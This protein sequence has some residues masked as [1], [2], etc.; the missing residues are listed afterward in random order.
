MSLCQAGIDFKL[1]TLGLS[2]SRDAPF[3]RAK[4]R[5]PVRLNLK[6][7]QAARVIIGDALPALIFAVLEL[8][9]PRSMFARLL[10]AA[11]LTC[12]V[13]SSGSAGETS[14][15]K[16]MLVGTQPDHPWATHMYLHECRMLAQCLRLTP[17]VEAVVVEDWPRDPLALQRV[18]SLVYYSRPAGD[19]V[20]SQG[21]RA[22][23]EKLMDEGT[24]FVA[25]HWATDADPQRG[26]DYLNVLGGWFNFAHS[27][28]KIT[29][30]PLRQLNQDH[31]ICRGWKEYPLHDEIYLNLK[32]HQQA[33]PLVTIEVD[34]KDQTVAW[35]FE[36]PGPHPGRSFG[37]TLGHFH[38][39][40]EIEAFRR[41]LVNGILWTAKVDVPPHGA[42]VD[43]GDADLK[44][45]PEPKTEKP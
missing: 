41:F 33:R 7:S 37:T 20:L 4:R 42:A 14:A 12:A 2:Q 17:G 21:H 8:K 10:S 3:T 39:N 9:G 40:F 45:P 6:Q 34:G 35:T 25:I 24:G 13:V 36:R 30:G 23:F 1:A 5:S 38:E 44:L 29:T 22:Q 15:T 19:I 43:V 31:P 32:F 18:T 16:I 28:L 11:V 27:G 26:A